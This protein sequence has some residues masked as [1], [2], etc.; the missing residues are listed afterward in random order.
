ML[1][2]KLVLIAATSV[3]G[4]AVPEPTPAAQQSATCTKDNE[5]LNSLKKLG[6][7]GTNFCREYVN[8]PTT[9]TVTATITPSPVTT[10]TTAVVTITSTQCGQQKRAAFPPPKHFEVETFAQGTRIKADKRTN[11]PFQIAR[12]PPAKIADACRCLCLKPKLPPTTTITTITTFAP[13]PTVSVTTTATAC[14]ESRPPV[15]AAS[16]QPCNMNDPGKC[17]NQMCYNDRSSTIGPYC[18]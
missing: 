18:L 15:C 4:V 8:P 16:G 5:I 11:I 14:V 13:A 2:L 1:A 10:T 3:L 9:S 7:S 12:F 17:C 6:V